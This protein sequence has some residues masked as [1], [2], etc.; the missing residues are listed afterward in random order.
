MECKIC[1]LTYNDSNNKPV[2]ITDCGHSFCE[3]CINNLENKLC[4]ICRSSINKTIINYDI[5]ESLNTNV[6]EE[7]VKFNLKVKE[8]ELKTNNTIN[9]IKDQIQLETVRKIDILNKKKNTLLK[10]LDNL[11]HEHQ[12]NIKNLEVIDNLER[13]DF[14]YCFKPSN[15]DFELN[16]GEL[17][18]N[19]TLLD[20]SDD[21]FEANTEI[22][23]TYNKAINLKNTGNYEESIQYFDKIIELNPFCS[24]AYI[25]KGLALL[26]LNKNNQAI[27]LLYKGDSF[28]QLKKYEEAIQFYDKSIDLDPCSACYE[29]KGNA[30]KMLKNYVEAINCYEKAI[31]LDPLNSTA[32]R[33][34]GD[35]LYYL[36]MYDKAIKSY[37]RANE[38]DPTNSNL[39]KERL[40]KIKN[41]FKK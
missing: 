33:G 16:I 1:F 21:E 34:K 17:K 39:K 32:Y 28:F 22:L 5:L 35:T 29:N 37:A 2:I 18:S 23:E 20:D 30:L 4:P 8:I 26:N 38:L 11:Q 19:K 9:L 41:F 12:N 31:E 7:N 27:K 6:E 14:S 24:K 25:N 3:T 15:S 13:I 36:K 10:K 40:A